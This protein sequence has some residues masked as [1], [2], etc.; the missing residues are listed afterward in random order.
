MPHESIKAALRAALRYHEIGEGS[1][2]RLYFA[3]K[4]ESGASFGFMQGDLNTG[5]PVVG[6]TFHNALA[7]GGIPL[8]KVASLEQQLSGHLR[9][10]PLPA[11][12]AGLVN[13][14]LQAS[15]VLIDAMDEELLHEVLDHLDACIMDASA[16][17]CEIDA[18]ALLY[19]ALWINMTGPPTKLLDWLGGGDPGLRTPVP[20]A[21]PRVEE[22]GIQTYLRA[23]LYFSENPQ[24]WPHMVE[25][26]EVGAVLLR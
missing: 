9:V 13:E 10:N 3:G 6:R 12:D 1:P 7:A 11:V 18:R 8:A 17:D 2:Y 25:A 5:P 21:A 14:A 20:P 4:G 26:V 24:N 19:I 15:R 23:T 22:E 16:A